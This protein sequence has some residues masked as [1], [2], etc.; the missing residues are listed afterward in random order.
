MQS[1]LLRPAT[2]ARPGLCGVF[3]APAFKLGIHVANGCIVDICFLPPSHPALAAT[4]P[5]AEAFEQS[6]LRYLTEPRHPFPDFPLQHAGS[7]FQRAVW[8]AIR[9]IPAGHTR[10]YGEIAADLGSHARA[11]GQACGANPFPV[12]VPCHRVIGQGRTGGFAHAREG[13]LLDAKR[14]LLMHEGAL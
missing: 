3:T 6:W 9:A 4:D 2:A 10:R 11:V 13:W 12:L 8:A 5:L 14:W 1:F 7:P